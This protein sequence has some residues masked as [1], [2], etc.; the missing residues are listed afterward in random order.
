[1][2]WYSY[3]MTHDTWNDL[4][5]IIIHSFQKPCLSTLSITG[6]NH[7]TSVIHRVIYIVAVISAFSHTMQCVWQYMYDRMI[8]LFGWNWWIY[9]SINIMFK[10]I[11]YFHQKSLDKICVTKLHILVYENK[12]SKFLLSTV[13]WVID[14]VN[15]QYLQMII[16]DST[17]PEVF[18]VEMNNDFFL[19]GS[20]L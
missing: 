14:N 19:W 1:M 11:I 9:Y 10:I 17:S 18:M 15:A 5:R 20:Y 4:L 3:F 6:R 2:K 12:T 16:H 7:E 8:Q 13:N